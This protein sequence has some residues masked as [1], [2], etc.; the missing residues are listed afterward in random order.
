V[1]LFVLSE[2]WTND[3]TNDRIRGRMMALYTASVSIGYAGGPL[4]LS[5]VGINAIAYIVGAAIALIA[6]APAVNPLV[7]PP[8]PMKLT[9]TVVLIRLSIIARLPLPLLRPS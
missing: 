3:L 8:Q 1:G 5:M 2:T 4:I 7:L 6:V 9:T